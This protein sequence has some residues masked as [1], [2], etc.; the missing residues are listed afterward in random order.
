MNADP[1]GE[2][3]RQW[4]THWGDGPTA[5]M[6]AVTSVMRVQQIL[7]GR[8]NVTLKP[9]ELTFPRYEALMVLYLSRRGSL[10]LGKIGERL[11]VH[12]TSVTS[13]IDGLE[14]LGYLRRT[15]HETDRRMT[16]AEITGDGR[17]TA[18][19]ATQALNDARFGTRPM[20]RSELE[21]IVRALTPLRADIDGFQ[22]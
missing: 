17:K 2:A 19:E 8:L 6:A 13:L 1:I 5:A 11:Q 12:P 7:I 16:L 15:P 18:L 22:P 9:F 21:T 20:Q 10:P 4:T 14:R 3:R